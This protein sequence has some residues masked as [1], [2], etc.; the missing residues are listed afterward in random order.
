MTDTHP[1]QPSGP[2]ADPSPARL[3]AQ[4]VVILDRPA[5]PGNI[6]AVA[7]AMGNTGFTRL[8]LVAPRQFPHPDAEAYAVGCTAILE[9]A[10]IFADLPSALADL[11][12][13]VATSNRPRGQRQVVVT[14]DEL[15]IRLR[16]ALVPPDIRVGLLFGTERT[17]LLSEDVERANLVCHIPTR[18]EQGSLNL[19]QAVLIVL[20]A[21][22][23]ALQR[24]RGM[25]HDP[26]RE[27]LPATAAAM[28]HLFAHMEETLTTIGFLKDGQKRHM[29]GSIK[30]MFQRAGLDRREV[31][32]LR[33]ILHEVIAWRERP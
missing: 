12:L 17:G 8:R 24:E 13:V 5:H 18:G 6:G 15:G 27:D 20:Y 23:Q 14:P 21:A 32:I 30:A 11:H 29:M 1:D 31:S 33:G 10:E 9:D 26:F 2:D 22:M 7:R 28:E 4:L 19:A 25:A 3:S 16:E